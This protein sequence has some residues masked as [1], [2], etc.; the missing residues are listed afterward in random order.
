MKRTFD[1]C[2]VIITC[3]IWLMMLGIL[4]IVV[5][6][7]SGLPVFFR[8]ERAGKEGVAFTILKLRSMRDTRNEAG[9]LL[10]DVE[11]LTRFGRFLRKTSLDEIPEL[12]LV[13]AGKMS[14]VGPRP[15][16]LEYMEHYD[17]HQRRRLEILPGITGW[18][19]VHGRNIL[20]WEDRFE[21]DIWY[22]DNHSIKLDIRIL[23]RTLLTV[24]TREGISHPGSAT[25]HKFGSTESDSD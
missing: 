12:L 14:L 17:E 18:A 10:P 5:A 24:L 6:I 3:P 25:M 15:L 1:L 16:L 22:V 7:D 19:Q 21:L 4:S 9:D 23:I 8:Q 2:L 11:R 13:L 20:S